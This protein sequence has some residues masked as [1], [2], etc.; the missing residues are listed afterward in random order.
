MF[1]VFHLVIFKFSTYLYNFINYLIFCI[2]ISN[3]Y[4]YKNLTNNYQGKVF[5]LIINI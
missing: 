4:I 2:T 3:P 5:N 1:Y